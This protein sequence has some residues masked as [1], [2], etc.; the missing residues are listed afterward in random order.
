MK[1]GF[2]VSIHREESGFRGKNRANKLK[3]IEQIMS[4]AENVEI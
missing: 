4:L 1:I 2:E 3:T